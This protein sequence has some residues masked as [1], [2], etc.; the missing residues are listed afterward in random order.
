[1]K[2]KKCGPKVKTKSPTSTCAQDTVDMTP[3]PTGKTKMTHRGAGRK[4]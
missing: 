1:M 2:A 3:K 4:R